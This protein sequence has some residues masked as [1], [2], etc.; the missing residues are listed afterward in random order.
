MS[1]LHID[2]SSTDICTCGLSL[3]GLIHAID[4]TDRPHAQLAPPPHPRAFPSMNNQVLLE[5]HMNIKNN[6]IMLTI[7]VGL[8]NGSEMGVFVCIHV[9]L[10]MN[11]YYT[12]T[13]IQYVQNKQYNLKP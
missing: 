7:F 8:S 4:R 5:G 13:C 12:I 10:S 3:H 11:D 9:M 6:N 1:A 2:S